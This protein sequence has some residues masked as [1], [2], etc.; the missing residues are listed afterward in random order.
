[1]QF[2]KLILFKHLR[3]KKNISYIKYKGKY[4]ILFFK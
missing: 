3:I 2:L 1:M 4:H